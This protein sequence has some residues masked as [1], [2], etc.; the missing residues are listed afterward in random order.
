MDF[1]E[2]LHCKS[3]LLRPVVE[4]RNQKGA[5]P[6]SEEQ[7]KG[8]APRGLRGPASAR[9]AGLKT[10]GSLT[11]RLSPVDIRQRVKEM[12]YKGGVGV[13]W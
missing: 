13:F 2:Q 11:R 5:F 8:A 9:L 10:G 4:H 7:V 3:T 12:W 1:A 6:C